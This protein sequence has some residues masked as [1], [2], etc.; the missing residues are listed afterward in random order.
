MKPGMPKLF[1]AEL[2]A[3]CRCSVL[4]QLGQ[5]SVVQFRPGA[6]ISHNVIFDSET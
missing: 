2:L 6:V 5:F 3:D 1:L 4:G